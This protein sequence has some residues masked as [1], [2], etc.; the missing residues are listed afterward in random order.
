M[1]ALGWNLAASATT[2][3]PPPPPPPPATPP[4]GISVSPETGYLAY[5]QTRNGLYRN[6][7]L[8]SVTE[9]GGITGDKFTYTLGGAGTLGGAS[10]SS[11]TLTGIGNSAILSAGGT[12]V[13]GSANGTL[14]ALTVTATDATT[15][16]SSAATPINVV[17]GG[18]GANVVGLVQ[19]PGFSAA[20]GNGG[21]GGAVASGTI[22]LA[23][24]PGI[25]A[26]APT[27][28][29][30]LGGS[31]T[32]DG[33]G[34]T[35][36]VRQSLAD[37]VPFPRRLGMPEEYGA[38]ALHIIANAYLNGEVIRLDGALRMAPR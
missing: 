1:D 31:D 35:P 21:L 5:A 37:G 34:M 25:A 38:L 20:P 19:A 3:P 7:P 30:G 8:A 33:T 24:I 15:D 6:S 18:G 14:Y 29:Y 12:G 17:V 23:S 32:I 2:P 28:I 4:S 13:A 26:A 9:A 27:F 22:S 11:F 10:A 16:V 36:E